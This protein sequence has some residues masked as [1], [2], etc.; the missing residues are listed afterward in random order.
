MDYLHRV[1]GIHVIYENKPLRNI[2]NYI[3]S[4]YDLK[5]VTLNGVEAVFAYPQIELES[6]NTVKTHI[7]KIKQLY[8][9]PVVLIL[10]VLSYRYKEYLLR[11][12]IPFVVDGKQIYLPFM[13]VYLQERCDNEFYVPEYLLPSAQQLLLHFIYNGCRPM[14]T[15]DAA[16]WLR[17]T[18]TSISRAS[19]QLT[20]LGLVN[21]E[22][23]G[24]RKMLNSDYT[25]RDLFDH[26]QKHLRNPIKKTIYV[27]RYEIHE[28]LLLSGYSA[29]SEYSM[30]NPSRIEYY[31]TD[32][33][34]LLER[35]SS[36]RLTNYTDQCAVELWR[37]DPSVLSNGRCVDELSLALS[38]RE[39]QDERIEEAIEDMLRKVWRDIDGTRYREF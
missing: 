35:H 18:A 29:L 34:A 28:K 19:R 11:D 30:L 24:V 27:P 32:S 22:T 7:E 12:H 6:V 2:P 15:S 4:R 33:I 8:G 16:A 1:L 5:P 31:A 13:A 20:D 38:L 17:L 10:T 9:V 25:P 39:D 21:A 26:S 36:R 14:A 37:Y 23:I 3:Y